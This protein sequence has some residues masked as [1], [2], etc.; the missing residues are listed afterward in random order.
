MVRL[1][2]VQFCIDSDQKLTI[3]ALL[4]RLPFL[5]ARKTPRVAI[6]PIEEKLVHG[7]SDDH[8][9]DKLLQE[10]MDATTNSD[11]KLFRQALEGLVMAMFDWDGDNKDEDDRK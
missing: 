1:L 5:K 7:S 6:D 9:N 11:V 2:I 10:L 3:L 8:I 4:M